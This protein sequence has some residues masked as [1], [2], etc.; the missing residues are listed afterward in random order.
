MSGFFEIR[1]GCKRHDDSFGLSDVSIRIRR[2][3]TLAL[4]GPSGAGKTTLLRLAAG[5]EDLEG[6]LIL[7]DGQTISDESHTLAPE[8][9][10]IG[11]VFQTLGLWS[12]LTAYDHLD[13][14]LRR[15]LRSK[16]E[17]SEEIGRFLAL[18]RLEGKDWRKPGQL[19]G[20]ERQRLALAR[21]LAPLPRLVLLDEPFAHVDDPLRDELAADLLGLIESC[22]ATVLLVSHDG[23]H[24]ASVCDEMAILDEGRIVQCGAPEEIYRAPATATAARMTGPAFL[25]EAELT[26]GI[27]RSAVGPISVPGAPNGKGTVCLRPES[28]NLHPS[29]PK[30]D[31]PSGVVVR[32]ASIAG[33]RRVY[34]RIGDNEFWTWND[35]L[36]S[37]AK[38]IHVEIVNPVWLVDKG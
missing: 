14:V 19:S 33:R 31:L 2:G 3:Q 36:A 20:G 11:M 18:A 10:G 16:T 37:K 21:A 13:L 29:P 7:L 22:G 12:H 4:L 30:P 23:A 6:G 9:R 34:F 8:Q 35:G 26:D 24:A 1:G 25:V 32:S 38:E 5:L 27:A 28:F 17:R 15:R